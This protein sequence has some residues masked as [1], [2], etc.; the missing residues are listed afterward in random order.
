MTVSTRTT[1]AIVDDA[2]RQS[3]S[4]LVRELVNTVVDRL[5]QDLLNQKPESSNMGTNR[6]IEYGMRGNSQ[7]SK[8]TKIEFFKFGGDDVRGWLFK[9]EQFFKVDHIADDFKGGILKRF[10]VT[11]DDPLSEIKKLRQ[12]GTVQEY[13]DAFDRLLCRINLEEDQCISFFLVG[14]SNGIELAVRMFKLR[15]LAE[16]YGLCKLEEAK[17]FCIWKAFGS[18]TRDFGSFGEEADKTTDLHQHC[19]RISPQ[20]LETASHTRDAVTTISKTASQDLKTVSDYT[21]HPII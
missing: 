9:C 6:N 7:F 18:N 21:T 4:N 8:V 16:V 14:L 3:L 2:T 13:I 11:Y 17:V 19:S 5:R 15:T 1:A 12:T 10:D 20:K